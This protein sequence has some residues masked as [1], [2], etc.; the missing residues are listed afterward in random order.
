M[1]LAST[2][3]YMIV[4][5]R[6]RLRGWTRGDH[7]LGEWARIARGKRRGQESL[8]PPGLG[9]GGSSLE[10]IG[11]DIVGKDKDKSCDKAK[12]RVKSCAGWDKGKWKGKGEGKGKWKPSEEE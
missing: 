8:A 6:E 3:R 1:D 12:G 2:F 10:E 5:S 11:W 7:E 4:F 9:K